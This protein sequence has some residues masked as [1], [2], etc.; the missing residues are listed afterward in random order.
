[1]ELI[2]VRTVQSGI[3]TRTPGA[4]RVMCYISCAYKSD[5]RV[6]TVRAICPQAE[7]YATAQ[8]FLNMGGSNACRKHVP[9]WIVCHV[10]YRICTDMFCFFFCRWQQISDM[11]NNLTQPSIWERAFLPSGHDDHGVLNCQ[12]SET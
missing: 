11:Q 1:M 2:I 3:L 10:Q 8:M 12:Y 9:E 5:Q 7:S 6:G 4:R